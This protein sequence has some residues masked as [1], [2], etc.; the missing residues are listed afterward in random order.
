MQIDK[1]HENFPRIK[2]VFLMN[3]RFTTMLHAM[4]MQ[5]NSA[6]KDFWKRI[7]LCKHNSESRQNN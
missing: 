7:E 3:M 2:V 6:V 5:S 4:K 1:M